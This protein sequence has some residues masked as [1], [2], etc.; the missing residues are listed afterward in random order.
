MNSSINVC[1]LSPSP[2]LNNVQKDKLT[3]CPPASVC[4][5][6]PFSEALLSAGV[7]P[8]PLEQ[9]LSVNVA[10]INVANTNPYTFFMFA[11]L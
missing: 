10:D 1:I 6:P 5:L 3:F 11:P 9:A 2:P 4:W 8:L 7:A